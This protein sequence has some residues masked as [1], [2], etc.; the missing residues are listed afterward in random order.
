[1]D[2]REGKLTVP[3][4]RGDDEAAP[5][6]EGEEAP[7]CQAKYGLHKAALLQ[8]I[9]QASLERWV[10]SQPASGNLTDSEGLFYP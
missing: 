10:A 7:G 5:C 1:M 9:L 3:V 2:N 6:Q 8:V 4:G